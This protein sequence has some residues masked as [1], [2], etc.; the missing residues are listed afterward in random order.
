VKLPVVLSNKFEFEINLKVAKTLGLKVS[1]NLLSTV[2]EVIEWIGGCPLLAQS[3]H[4]IETGVMSAIGGKANIVRTC[5][6][7]R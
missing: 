7:V 2:D 5:C 1:G 6:N 4:S 3:E